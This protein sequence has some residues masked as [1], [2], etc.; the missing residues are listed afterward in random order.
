MGYSI[1]EM[2]HGT[3]LNTSVI[4]IHWIF[5]TKISK[6]KLFFH[7]QTKC[8]PCNHIYHYHNSEYNSNGKLL[9]DIYIYVCVCV[10]TENM[11]D[12]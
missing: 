4:V 3:V 2:I 10:C 12:E 7:N 5:L 9:Y 8:M 11:N 6:E 1:D